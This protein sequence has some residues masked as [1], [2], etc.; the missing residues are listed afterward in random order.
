MNTKGFYIDS[1]ERVDYG[2]VREVPAIRSLQNNSLIC[3]F[4]GFTHEAK[5]QAA[6]VCNVMNA[7]HA[8]SKSLQEVC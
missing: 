8:A 4:H 1:V 2:R 6:I 7:A 3:E 5:A